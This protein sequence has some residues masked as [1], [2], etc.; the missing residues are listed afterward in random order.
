MR[1]SCRKRVRT[2]P[3]TPMLRV[4]RLLQNSMWTITTFGI[5]I[6][7]F[8]RLPHKPMD[9]NSLSLPSRREFFATGYNTFQTPDTPSANTLSEQKSRVSQKAQNL[10]SLGLDGFLYS[11]LKL[12]LA[13]RLDWIPNALRHS[14]APQWQTISSCSRSLLRRRAYLGK[15]YTTWMRR[16]VRGVV[17][18]KPHL[19]NT[20]YLIIG[21][22]SIRCEVGIWSLSQLSSASAL[23]EAVLNPDLFSL[24]RNT[25][26][27][28]LR[29]TMISG[30][31]C[32]ILMHYSPLYFAHNAVFAHPQMAG[33]TTFYVWNGLKNVSYHRQLLETHRRKFYSFTMDTVLTKLTSYA[34][35]HFKIIFIYFI[36]LHIR[37]TTSSLLMSGSLVRYRGLGLTDAMMSWKNL[38]A[39]CIVRISL[40]NIWKYGA[41]HS[42]QQQFQRHGRTVA[43]TRL[44]Q[45]YLQTTTLHP[46]FLLRLWRMS[47]LAFLK[48]QVLMM[49]M[50]MSQKNR[51][52]QNQVRGSHRI[53]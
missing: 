25:A 39:K 42:Q 16:V 52:R 9:I 27:N 20:S 46:A 37:R 43:Y 13:S 19:G 15:M 44:I 34:S 1:L 38:F 22:Q 14:T 31:K 18:K 11:T 21:D 7:V 50:V 8:I 47:H 6:T 2:L 48:V 53:P 3:R 49:I 10:T 23:M 36:C 51:F 12:S 30:R 29:Q 5:V 33:P 26:V 45:T 35:W 40:R 17:D 32:Y 41:R 4:Q 24:A 28:N